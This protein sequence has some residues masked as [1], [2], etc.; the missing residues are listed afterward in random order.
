MGILRITVFLVQK[1]LLEFTSLTYAW[2]VRNHSLPE[3]L[4]IV[5]CVGSLLSGVILAALSLR[6][7]ERSYL[8]ERWS[9]ICLV[10]GLCLL[11]VSLR[12]AR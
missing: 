7:R 3:D 10:L 11:G 9:G 6:D 12:L 4:L 1:S 2:A 5:I 8:L